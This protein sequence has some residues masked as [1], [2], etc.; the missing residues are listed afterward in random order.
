MDTGTDEMTNTRLLFLY[1]PPAKIFMDEDTYK[2]A[3]NYSE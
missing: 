3:H 1:F 2:Y